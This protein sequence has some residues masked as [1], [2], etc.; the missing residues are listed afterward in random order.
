MAAKTDIELA[1]TELE[2][3]KF[4]F[5]MVEAITNHVT[6]LENDLARV[7]ETNESAARMLREQEYTISR[8]EGELRK[9]NARVHALVKANALSEA[10]LRAAKRGA[11]VLSDV[12]VIAGEQAV[13]LSKKTA[14]W[15]STID[16]AAEFERAK[17]YPAT[18]KAQAAIANFDPQAEWRKLQS[19][20]LTDKASR[21]LHAAWLK[22]EEYLPVVQKQ[23]AAL[24]EKSTDFIANLNKKSV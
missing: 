12:S 16:L 14:A 4:S 5:R 21:E 19:H 2:A 1:L 20:P 9:V 18:Q 10:A 6:A 15:L 7:N 8:L 17:S 3:G 23:L 11:A 22:A 13:A 24:V